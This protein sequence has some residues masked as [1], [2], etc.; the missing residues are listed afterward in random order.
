MLFRSYQPVW[1][2]APED[3]LPGVVPVELVIA[4]SAST[5]VMLTGIRAF[6]QGLAMNLAIRVRG[7]IER[8][9]LHSEVFDGPY[10]HGMDEQWQTER[11][12]WGFEF[13]DGRRATNVDPPAWD[14][15]EER[16]WKDK[17]WRP[18]RPVLNG[19]G[20]GGSQRAIDRDYWLWPLPP[21]GRLRVVFQWPQQGI[22][23]TIHD[24]DAKPFLDAAARSQR[25]WGPE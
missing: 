1:S 17:T 2:N 12:K 7:P 18:D 25:V 15:E 20:G 4:R 14:G 3:V 5:V 21:P 19:Q 16:P 9:D 10:R 13:A 23:T 24:L 6:P 11:L 8:R 22:T